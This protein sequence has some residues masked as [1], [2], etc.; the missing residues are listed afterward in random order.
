ML[1]VPVAV[2]RKMCYIWHQLELTCT[3]YETET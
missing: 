2:L 3:L 1:P